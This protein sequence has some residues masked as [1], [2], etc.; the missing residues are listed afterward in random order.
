MTNPSERARL[1]SSQGRK[2]EAE[3]HR[4]S[5]PYPGKIEN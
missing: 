2:R 1:E 5:H 4:P 3:P